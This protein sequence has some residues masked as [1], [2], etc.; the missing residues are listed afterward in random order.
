[1]SPKKCILGFDVY[2]GFLLNKRE[3]IEMI[4]RT[5]EKI[6]GKRVPDGQGVINRENECLES[7]TSNQ[8]SDEQFRDNNVDALR[9]L[10]TPEWFIKF[11]LWFSRK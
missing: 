1:L 2:A 11:I 9:N 6:F 5:T 3:R 7:D 10:N 8:F 4:C